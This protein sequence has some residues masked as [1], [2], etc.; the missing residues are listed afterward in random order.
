MT[1]GRQPDLACEEWHALSRVGSSAPPA[2]AGDRPLYD[3]QP[4]PGAL[5]LSPL[6]RRVL[7][8]LSLGGTGLTPDEIVHPGIR[9]TDVGA[10]AVHHNVAPLVYRG[11]RALDRVEALPER[12]G[13]LRD[14]CHALYIQ[15]VAGNAR[16]FAE[17]E[18]VLG[19][20]RRAGIPVI[21]LKGAAMTRSL[22]GDIGLRYMRDLDLLVPPDARGHALAVLRTLGYDI[23]PGAPADLAAHARRDGL[24]SLPTTASADAATQLY[25]R[26]HF[27]YHL[28]RERQ[29]FSLELHWHIVKPGR[30]CAID[31]FWHEAR[32]APVGDVEALC[33]RPEHLLLHL[34]L[35]LMAD[36]YPQL[37]L[38][39]FIDVHMAS[40]RQ[41][42]DWAWLGRSARRHDA[43]RALG[44]ALNLARC[45]LGVAAPYPSA[46]WLGGV[47]RALVA[48]LGRR[49]AADLRPQTADRT[50]LCQTL[51][52]TIARRDRWGNVPGRLYRQF[53]SYPE[54]N[55]WLPDRYRDSELKNLLYAL[56][57]SRVAHLL[58]RARSF[59]GGASAALS[60]VPPKPRG[61]RG[62]ATRPDGTVAQHVV[63]DE[64]QPGANWR[65]RGP[66]DVRTRARELDADR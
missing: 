37:R 10:V 27:H 11:L 39:R 51:T 63:S 24:A 53:A 38:A 5:P 61:P 12:A 14:R 22:F 1:S 21:L 4:G 15:N 42:L 64:P 36:E 7:V 33:F 31:E 49:W 52:W 57:P 43:R 48:L 41:A 56:H 26:Y 20:L 59:G 8:A 2:I 3:A 30:R 19:P 47:D 40:T 55:L 25:D 65:T 50:A 66:D 60:V 16:L 62:P 28:E 13:R 32:P 45:V 9:W 54:T 35:H 29:A 46:G 58:R 6:D 44:V 34:A 18:R 17:L 23:V